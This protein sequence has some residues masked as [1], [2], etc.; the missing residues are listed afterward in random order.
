MKKLF[1]IFAT[2][3][4]T[5]TVWAQTPQ[6]IS[7]QAVIRDGS[8]NLDTNHTVGMRISILQGTTPV[9]VETH[10]TTTNINGLVSIEIGNGT[11]VSGVAFSAIDWSVGQYFIKTETDPTGGTNYPAIVGTSQL[12][13]VPYALHAKTAD[14]GFSG[15]YN[16]LSNQPTIPTTTNQLTNNSGFLTSFTE[17]DPIFGAWNK[18]TGIS[19]IASQVSDFQAN[20]TN[21]AS[22]T[23]NTAKVTN[24]THT[25]DVTGSNALTIANKVTMTGTA[26]VTI[27]G[28]PTVIAS[29]PV[30]ISIAAATTSAAGSMS[31]AD[32]TKLNGITAN[33]VTYTKLHVSDELHLTVGNST[34]IGSIINYTGLLIEWRMNNR[35]EVFQQYIYLSAYDKDVILG[36]ISLPANYPRRYTTIVADG[37][38]TMMWLG[39]SITGTTLTVSTNSVASPQ[40][41]LERIYKIE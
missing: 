34:D 26:P 32:K 20:V 41:F 27:T 38:A 5:A 21:N 13:S 14:N 15:N 36:N 25:G 24:A 37:S 3:L 39:V 23:A 8:G 33:G 11:F 4:L 29:N 35:P 1:T 9:Y 31:A 12:L 28:N 2:V 19:I 16:D 40:V 30:A 10:A 18:S 22:V 17:T 7:Y 6:K